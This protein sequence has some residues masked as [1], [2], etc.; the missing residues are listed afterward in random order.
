[1]TGIRLTLN[2]EELASELERIEK[3]ASRPAAIYDAIGAHLVFSTQRRFETETGPDGAPWQRLSPR[4]ANRRIGRRQR[5]YANILRQSTRLYRSISHVAD[6]RGVEWG[7]NVEY[8]AIHQLGGEIKQPERQQRLFLKTIR[9]KGA[10]R[11]RFVSPGTKNAMERDVAIKAH[12]IKIPARPYLGV[13]QADRQR[14][15]EI[16]AEQLYG[17]GAQ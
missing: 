15:A 8:A 12:T 9:R 14:I 6:E 5:G 3:V 4:T 11:T 13:S 1:M 2:A 7:T 10:A 17:S 16:V